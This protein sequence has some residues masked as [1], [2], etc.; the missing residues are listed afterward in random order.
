MTE[1]LNN[2]NYNI[3]IA[4]MHEM[5]SFLIKDLDKT[6]KSETLL[7]NYSKILTTI[8]PVIP[9]FA[10]ECLEGLNK[11]KNNIW[12]QY[13]DNLIEEKEVQIVVQINGK[14]RGLIK[15]DKNIN[16][17]DL[18][19]L[20][21]EDEKISKHLNKKIKKRIYVKTKLMNLII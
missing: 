8:I 13:N 18:Y 7:E 16:E 14:K 1:N 19:S 10:N 20:I 12:P 15:V 21:I 2:F 4:N 3:L 17:E 6:Y 9:H 5:Y 11:N